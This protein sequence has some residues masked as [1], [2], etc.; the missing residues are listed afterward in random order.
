MSNDSV[1]IFKDVE[2]K[3]YFRVCSTCGCKQYSN[4]FARHLRSKKHKEVD[5][6]NQK[7][8]ITKYEPHVNKQSDYLILK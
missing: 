2:R 8:E 6:A 4:N 1:N 5:Y 3:N 7:F